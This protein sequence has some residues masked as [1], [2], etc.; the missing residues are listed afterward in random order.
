V[1]LNERSWR[2]LL[3]FPPGGSF[4]EFKARRKD[5]TVQ[6]IIACLVLFASLSAAQPNV[7]IASSL[8]RIGISDA[9]G[10]GTQVTLSAAK[11]GT[12]SFQI[13]VH[14]NSALSNVNVTI[15]DLSGPAIIPKS[16]FTL[17]R[18]KYVYVSSASPDWGGSNRPL[19]AGWYTD[20]L[21]PFTDPVTG[22]PLSG[23]YTAVPFSVSSAQNQ[24]IWVDLKVP[25][26]AAAGQYNGTY[27]VTSSQGNVTG[28]IT[29]TVWNFSLPNTPSLKSAFL[30]W[31]T[32]DLASQEELIKH[33]L[34][35]TATSGP[36]QSMLMNTYGLG[37]TNAGLWS[38]ADVSNCSMW[39]APSVAE[40]Q[41]AAAA[42]APGLY[43]Y[44]YSADEID[45]CPGLY[46]TLQQWASNMHQAGINNLVT[47]T[48]NPSLFSDGSGSGRSAVDIWV[49]L[50]VMY[51]GGG[52]YISQAL[53]KGDK[54]WSYNTLVQDAY[55]PKWEIDFD[56]ANF[57]IQPGFF[58][59]SL[60][61]TGL[62]YWRA[63]RFTNDPWN[64]PNTTGVFS[65]GNYP[66]EGMLV[67]PGAPV[68]TSG[69]V[70]SMRLKWLRD[71]VE[72]YEYAQVLKNV[73][74]PSLAL[75][76]SQ[77]VGPDWHNWSRDPNAIASARLQIGQAINQIV[78][79]PPAPAAPASPSP[80]NAAAAV[81]TA[82]T[83][84][85]SASAN[86]TSYDVY[87]GTSS[88]PQF[89][90]NTTATSYNPGTLMYSATYYWKV[91]AKNS[92][93]STSSPTW[94]FGTGSLVVQAQ[95][96]PSAVSVTPSSWTGWGRNFDFVYSSPAGFA[97]L[98]GGSAL[99]NSTFDGTHACWF[100]WDRNAN[101]LLL[102]SDDA[103]IWTPMP[104]AKSVGGSS[105][106]VQN[107]QCTI[108]NAWAVGSGNNLTVTVS[109]SFKKGF[110]G[111]KTVYMYTSD[112]AGQNSGYQARG[113]WN[114]TP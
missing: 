59:Q 104:V 108:W 77:S 90:G 91:V 110:A 98:N 95:T 47:M 87:F 93:G 100:Y 82:S 3:D 13:V 65:S 35:P 43:L 73:G 19:G 22:A 66:G 21:I 6:A 113:T 63:D 72:D 51:D 44:D 81:S 15:S 75:Q 79:G 46:S 53:Q 24:P 83:L 9:A 23:T 33:K 99:I 102:A 69:V 37:A 54:L 111:T 94:S 96:G 1:C 76:I 71:G 109:V 68:G 85:W 40:F 27:T 78:G 26:T 8:R 18:E 107:S 74:N 58:S 57:R 20:P 64:D 17:Y 39:P 48:P 101:N 106:K 55:S 5:F 29:L 14:G 84:T 2:A 31:A 105:A 30:Y 10:S 97:N 16:S 45:S 88:T 25:P 32:S 60:G 89:V 38:G 103:S 114:I 4:V 11:G 50:P 12:E 70:P 34:F 80:A 56:P 67:Y 61:L 112:S 52:A 92:G 86:A 42:Q 7:W 49:M 62:L 41:A 28:S 36:N